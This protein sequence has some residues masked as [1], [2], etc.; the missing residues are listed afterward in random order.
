MKVY[1]YMSLKE[2]IQVNKKLTRSIMLL[3]LSISLVFSSTAS[4]AQVNELANMS[5]AIFTTAEDGNP[6]NE[7]HFNLRK[8]VYLN[9]GPEK[10]GAA[11]LP[12]DFYYIRITTPEG[13]LLGKS[14]EPVIQVIG[15]KFV[16]LYSVWESVYSTSSEYSIIGYDLTDSNENN[17]KVWISKD[18]SFKNNESKTDNFKVSEAATPAIRITKLA[19][20]DF[21]K[22]GETVTYKFK[23]A[24]TGNV[25]LTDASVTDSKLGTQW[26]H[27]IDLLGVGEAV[28][29]DEPYIVLQDAV[30]P[31]INT[32][33]VTA[34]YGGKTVSGTSQD[35]IDRKL[36][37][38]SECSKNPNLTRKWKVRNLN[39]Y[40]I[41]FTWDIYNTNQTGGMNVPANS[42]VYFESVTESSNTAE[43]F[44]NGILHDTQVSSDETCPADDDN[45][46]SNDGNNGSNNDSNNDSNDNNNNN[47]G[48]NDSN[49]DNTSSHH[50]NDNSKD[51]TNPVKANDD[52]SKVNIIDNPAADDTPIVQPIGP[53]SSDTI[54]P[55]VPTPTASN[56]PSPEPD[57][58]Y[59]GGFIEPEILAGGFGL[60]L[61]ISGML[62]KPKRRQ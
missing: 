41:D 1:L 3:I 39:A 47:D 14:N 25:Y 27:D 61:F 13:N 40:N 50:H 52:E 20:R 12:D 36:I 49:N 44:V 22:P 28:Y 62:L 42:D 5:G 43:I 29:F 57:L 2:A 53:K 7:N 56:A 24:N 45:D 8:D 59:T 60:M 58:P 46:G 4:F 51:T 33:S 9:G 19:D 23:I 17:Y 38:S 16:E 6:V 37:L 11:G 31:L 18:N 26:K 10:E 21:T 55:T 30:F 54:T 15:N 35:F 34:N 32:A 48:N